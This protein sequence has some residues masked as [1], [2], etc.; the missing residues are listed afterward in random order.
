M[1]STL[2]EVIHATIDAAGVSAKSLLLNLFRTSP[3]N[4]WPVKKLI[5]VGDLFGFNANSIRVTLTRLKSSG[6]VELDVRGSYRLN[7]QYDPVRDWI[8]NWS[9]GEARVVEWDQ[10]WLCI[11]PPSD[12]TAKGARSLEYAATRL[13]FKKLADRA[14][15]RPNNLSMP[16]SKIIELLEAMSAC[17]NLAISI[18]SE[19]HIVGE[20]H[21]ISSLWNGSKLEEK[22]RAL[23]LRL[24]RSMKD[25][26]DADEK[27]ALRDSFLIGG[28]AI[29]RLALDPLLPEGMIDVEVREEFTRCTMSFISKFNGLWRDRFGPEMMD[30]LPS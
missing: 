16:T 29:R 14:W 21:S 25:L 13:G 4:H 28:D 3:S 2:P 18:V 20:V 26:E 17:S 1:R 19:V 15:L 5:E 10:Q 12:L 8:D 24:N 23:T 7:W 9:K 11:L 30:A 27:Q 6:L 22:Y